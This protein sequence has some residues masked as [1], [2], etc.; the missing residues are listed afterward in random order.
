M[1][2]SLT[3]Q[4][5][6]VRMDGVD[7]CAA[8]RHCV[9]FDYLHLGYVTNSA[10][11]DSRAFMFSMDIHLNNRRLFKESAFDAFQNRSFFQIIS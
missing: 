3:Q 9:G 11:L 10:A 2:N 5:H 7:V 1:I 6:W 8:T 4:K